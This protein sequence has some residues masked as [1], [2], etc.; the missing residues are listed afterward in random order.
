MQDEEKIMQEVD[1]HGKLEPKQ[2]V[3]FFKVLVK[4][5]VW[6]VQER[7]GGYPGHGRVLVQMVEMEALFKN[8]D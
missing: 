2:G 5:R 4:D 7:G 6:P 1:C 8:I 3:L